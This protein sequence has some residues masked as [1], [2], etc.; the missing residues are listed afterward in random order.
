MASRDRAS[1][2]A[3]L[4]ALTHV[5]RTVWNASFVLVCAAASALAAVEVVEAWR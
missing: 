2:P 1:D 5:P 4:A 3:V